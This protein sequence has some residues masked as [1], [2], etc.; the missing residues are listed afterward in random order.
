MVNRVTVSQPTCVTFWY[1]TCLCVE[2]FSIYLIC[3][4]FC[5]SLLCYSCILLLQAIR[6]YRDPAGEKALNTTTLNDTSDNK[7]FTQSLTLMEKPNTSRALSFTFQP[8]TAKMNLP[9]LKDDAEEGTANVELSEKVM[10][11]NSLD[12]EPPLEEKKSPSNGE[13]GTNFH[14]GKVSDSQL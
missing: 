14:H 9:T 7:A 1:I 4:F 5:T 10:Q 13:N 8:S 11:V 6:L 3:I 12:K 2:L